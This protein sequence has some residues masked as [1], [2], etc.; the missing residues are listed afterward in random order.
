MLPSRRQFARLQQKLLGG[1]HTAQHHQNQ[2]SDSRG[3]LHS[4]EAAQAAG[5]HAHQ[6]NYRSPFMDDLVRRRHNE[7]FVHHAGDDGP[8]NEGN[9][10]WP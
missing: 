10:H 4:A 8:K 5:V 7:T 1:K 9:P 3:S 2:A 6:G